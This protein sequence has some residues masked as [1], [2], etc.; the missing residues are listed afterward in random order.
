MTGLIDNGLNVMENIHTNNKQTDFIKSFVR[1]YGF[2]SYEATVCTER[3][4][5]KVQLGCT[6]KLADSLCACVALAGRAWDD[7][8]AT[9]FH[10]INKDKA[11][12]HRAQRHSDSDN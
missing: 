8:S 5:I 7:Q 1:N 4:E 10:Y 12:E 6:Q 9:K 3:S 11:S 2:L